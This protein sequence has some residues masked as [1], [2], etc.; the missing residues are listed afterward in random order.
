MFGSPTIPM[1][2][3]LHYLKKCLMTSLKRKSLILGDLQEVHPF[4]V[5]DVVLMGEIQMDA[6]LDN[7]TPIL[8]E[9]VAPEVCTVT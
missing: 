8:M 1:S 3:P 5:K 9:P 7:W 4:L 2:L 6:R